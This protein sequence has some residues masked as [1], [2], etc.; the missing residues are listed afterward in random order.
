MITVDLSRFAAVMAKAKFRKQDLIDVE[1]PGALVAVNGMRQRVPVDTGALRASIKP[2]IIES[3]DTR[4]V[5]DVGPEVEYGPFIEYGTGVYAE[6]GKG[7]KGGWR[8]KD[9]NGWHFTMGMRPQPYMRPTIDE[10]GD[11]IISAIEA[12]IKRKLA[13]L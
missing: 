11:K 7:R 5:D 12:A 9:K 13:G 8:Y 1:G 3:T 2:H 6:G 4:L 10:D